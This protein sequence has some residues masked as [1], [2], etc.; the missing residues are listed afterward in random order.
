MQARVSYRDF[1]DHRAFVTGYH[2]GAQ[3]MRAAVLVSRPL[4]VSTNDQFETKFKWSS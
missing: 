4:C 2:E 1:G 3:V